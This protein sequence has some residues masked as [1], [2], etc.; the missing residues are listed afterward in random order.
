MAMVPRKEEDKFFPN[1]DDKK[2]YAYYWVEGDT[3]EWAYGDMSWYEENGG[4]PDD[5]TRWTFKIHLYEWFEEADDSDLLLTYSGSYDKNI[6]GGM[7]DDS[8][9]DDL[10]ASGYKPKARELKKFFLS[11]SYLD[12]HIFVSG[13]NETAAK[14]LDTILMEN[15]PPAVGVT[16]NLINWN[17][18]PPQV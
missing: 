1:D 17:Q 8:Y 3:P 9:S 16:S 10:D 12:F 6:D 14:R 15:F 5:W 13:L 4:E 7:D 18:H 2:F 11:D